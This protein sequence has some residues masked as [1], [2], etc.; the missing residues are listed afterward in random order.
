MDWGDG[1]TTTAVPNSANQWV[2]VYSTYGAFSLNLTE[3]N[4][5][6]TGYKYKRDYII[7]STNQNQQQ[8]WYSPHQV[9][10][11]FVD[12]NQQVVS[13]ATINATSD[14]STLP[15]GLAGSVD[16]LTNMYGIKAEQAQ[17]MIDNATH[18]VGTTSEDGRITFTMHSSLR[19]SI[20]ITDS[21]GHE[22]TKVVYPSDTNY[23]ITLPNTGAYISPDSTNNT[24]AAIGNSTVTFY[25][26]DTAHITLGVDYLD[27]SG[28]TSAL[29]FYALMVNNNTY[30]NWTNV[31]VTGQEHVL[32]NK[33]Y[34][35]VRGDQWKWGYLA[36]RTV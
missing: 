24:Y 27:I 18:M 29:Q 15:G 2:H 12:R 25:E 31:S 32:L 4:S 35:N 1:Q 6:G 36:T 30:M 8:T 21:V 34:E 11:K 5:I 3:T 17:Q 14:Q 33:T 7:T 20:N 9:A 23:I 10:F 26:P 28:R 16:S 13:G 22:Y 19:Y